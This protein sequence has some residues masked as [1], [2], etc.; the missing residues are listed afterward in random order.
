M[1][2]EM[3]PYGVYIKTDDAGRIVDINSSD[4]LPDTSG[5]TLIDEGYGDKYHH[6]QGNYLPGALMDLRGLLRYKLV[7]GQIQERTAEEMDADYTEPEQ[8]AD[9]TAD[10]EQKVEG[11]QAVLSALLGGPLKQLLS[12]DTKAVLKKY[13]YEEG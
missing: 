2:F 7:D 13:G 5:W 9:P 6:A 4:F 3:Q 10:L 11:L 8:A 1:N 12:E